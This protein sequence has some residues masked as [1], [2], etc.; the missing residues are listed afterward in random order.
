MKKLFLLLTCLAVLLGASAADARRRKKEP[1]PPPLKTRLVVVPVDGGG[2]LQAGL[3]EL[4]TSEL[5]QTNR[6][7]ILERASLADVQS[8]QARAGDPSFWK[9]GGV[10]PRFIPGRMLL[11]IRAVN[12]GG[13]QDALVG[14]I[15]EA[16][17]AGFRVKRARVMLEVKL[18]D[19]STA[20]V[21]Q[22]R[23]VEAGATGGDLAA[24]VGTGK[25]LIGTAMFNS[26]AVGKA[27]KE[28][29]KKSVKV[30]MDY[31]SNGR[32]ET[33][34]A[35]VTEAGKV[36]VASGSTDGVTV[37]LALNLF[38]PGEAIIDPTTGV[39]LDVAL[40]QIGQLRIEEVFENYS[41]GAAVSDT[42]PQRGDILK[43]APR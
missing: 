21:V 11:S 25:T 17:G 26:S 36:Y 4:L 5:M 39:Q 10:P 24:G 23:V 2:S 6:F 20:Q 30:I 1:P 43:P 33:R 32:W 40:R 15:G 7:V 27:A 22:S 9:E 42:T 41:V 29:I 37:G 28:A 13:E 14:T 38:R 12:L 3:T 18:I 34:V 8:E 31:F 35:G 19:V 16:G